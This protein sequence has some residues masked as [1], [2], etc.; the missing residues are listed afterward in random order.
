[1]QRVALKIDVD[2]LRGTLEGVPALVEVLARHGCGA[3][4]FFSLGPDNTGRALRR[5]FRRGFLG[6]VRRTSV[7]AHY[8]WRTLTYGVLWPGPH[9]GRRAAG[10]MRRVRER[11]F[12]VGV[13]CY[14]HVRW[15]D[16][17]VHRD[18]SWT[19]R[20]MERAC[21]AFREVF[22]C[23]PEAHAAAG[24]QLNAAALELEAALG[25]RYASDTRGTGPFLPS[26]NGT[27]GTCPQLPTTLPTLDELIGR[28][29]LTAEGAARE[30]LAASRVSMP[31]GH[32]FTLHAELEGMRL[33]PA[34][35]FLLGAWRDAGV[36]MVALGDVRATLE[37]A[38][39]PRHRI[40]MQPVAGR[41]GTLAVQGEAIGTGEGRP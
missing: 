14:D 13:H 28:D 11:G 32:I 15:Q 37:P 40:S 20:E 19:E 8:G 21:R 6:K 38:A 36:R 3:S 34:F 23:A 31:Q 39:L 1:M 24:W 4:F 25:F 17:V 9:I 33:R 35:E 30:I 2:T 27:A 29:G 10:V 16:N 18:A 7:V 22:G 5:V 41:S 26:W 12:E